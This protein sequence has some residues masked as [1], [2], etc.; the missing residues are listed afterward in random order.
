MLG[1]RSRGSDPNHLQA[2]W[3]LFSLQAFPVATSYCRLGTK[4][5]LELPIHTLSLPKATGFACVRHQR[6]D[7]NTWIKPKVCNIQGFGRQ[8][9]VN[10]EQTEMGRKK[11][12]HPG[13]TPLIEAT[14]L[15]KALRHNGN[16]KPRLDWEGCSSSTS[17]TF[18]LSTNFL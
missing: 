9:R 16:R 17:R 6:R 11:M 1:F 13:R 3:L 18:L 5:T 8:H 2:Q 4:D 15:C 12:R 7:E 14:C 10:S